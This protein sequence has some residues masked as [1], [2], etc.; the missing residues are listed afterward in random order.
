M[1]AA[2]SEEPEA[3]V[4]N[5]MPVNLVLAAR[6]AAAPSVGISQRLRQAIQHALL[7]KLRNPETDLRVRIAMA[8]AL[9]S[10]GGPRFIRH[11]GPHGDYLLS[12]FASI[13]GG[14]YPIGNDD[15]EY[16]DEKPAHKVEIAPFEM[17]FWF[18][19]ELCQKCLLL[20]L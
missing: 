10:L 14:I 9:G 2:M 20:Q 12:P 11:R 6:C 4:T 19:N 13:E 16:A 3:F 15:S 8:E 7:E 5:L 17:V 1:A 18:R